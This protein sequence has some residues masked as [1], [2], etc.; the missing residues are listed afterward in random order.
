M[1]AR[2]HDLALKSW[3]EAIRAAMPPTCKFDAQQ[4]CGH[5]SNGRSPRPCSCSTPATASSV[6]GRPSR[7]GLAIESRRHRVSARARRRRGAGTAAM[8]GAAG[9]SRARPPADRA[10]R[11]ARQLPAIRLYPRLGFQPV[12]A[13]DLQLVS[14]GGRPRRRPA[15]PTPRLT[16]AAS[17][18]R[19]TPGRDRP[20]GASRSSCCRGSRGCGPPISVGTCAPACSFMDR[21]RRP[22]PRT[23]TP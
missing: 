17:R 22:G 19:S 10:E 11:P 14:K 4:A 21:G 5:R 3:D 7:R 1:R 16:V 9:R 15:P 18:R 23:P 20:R 12:G 6:D 8:R 2:G 13:D